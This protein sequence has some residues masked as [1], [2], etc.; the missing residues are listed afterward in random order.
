MYGETT[1]RTILDPLTQVQRTSRDCGPETADITYSS[2]L[3]LAFDR[4][5]MAVSRTPLQSQRSFTSLNGLEQ[6][7]PTAKS[8]RHDSP[9]LASR[10]LSTLWQTRSIPTS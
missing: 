3:C 9:R 4:V 10:R 6:S 7:T 2:T 1:D 5:D 8:G